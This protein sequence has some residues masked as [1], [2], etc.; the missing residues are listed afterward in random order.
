MAIWGEPSWPRSSSA[1]PTGFTVL[2]LLAW[3]PLTVQ[4]VIVILAP[5]A[6]KPAPPFAV[7]FVALGAMML[8]W[9]VQLEKL[10]LPVPLL[11][12]KIANPPPSPSVRLLLFKVTLVTVSVAVAVAAL[13]PPV[14]KSNAPPH[15]S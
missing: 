13:L 15:P 14:S 9:T 2:A 7:P 8:F 10:A 11:V 4:P 3:L 6:T 1:P 5:T 12:L